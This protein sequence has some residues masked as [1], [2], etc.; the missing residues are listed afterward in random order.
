MIYMILSLISSL[1]Q[2]A[3]YFIDIIINIITNFLGNIILI[4]YNIFQNSTDIR[5]GYKALDKTSKD[6]LKFSL[7]YIWNDFLEK[8]KNRKL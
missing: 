7:K 6:Y 8:I 3:I 1:F 5:L 2:I 4:S